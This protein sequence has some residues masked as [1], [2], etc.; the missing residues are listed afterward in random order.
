MTE[1][2]STAYTLA[3]LSEYIHTLD[4]LPID[5]SRNFADLRE[6]DA[7][8]SS[9]IQSITAKIYKLISMIED[10]TTTNAD[11]LWLLSDIAAEAQRLKVGGEDKIR[12]A[13]QGADNL[14]AHAGHLRALTEHIPGFDT[15][16]LDRKTT[17]PH[18]SDRAYMP[19][20]IM[21]TGRRRRGGLGSIMVATNPEPSPAK[22]KRVLKE[23]DVDVIGRSPKKSIHAESSARARNNGRKK[24]AYIHVTFHESDCL[25]MYRNERVPSPSESLVSVAAPLPHQITHST[26]SRISTNI[27]HRTGGASDGSASNK[28]RTGGTNTI[29]GTPLANEA[30]SA[31]HDAHAHIHTNGSSRRNGAPA[32][33]VFNRH[34]HLPPPASHP[35]LPTP[36]QNGNG[37]GGGGGGSHLG[38]GYDAHGISHAVVQDWNGIPRA[39]QLGGPGMPVRSASIH[40]TAASVNVINTANAHMDTDT[41]DADG[42]G[43]DRTYCF[44]DGISYGEMIACDDENCERE[45]VRYDL[46]VFFFLI[47]IRSMLC[48]STL[49]VLALHNL[50]K[51]SGIATRARTRKQ[52]R[53]LFGVGREEQ[54][55]TGQAEGVNQTVFHGRLVRTCN[56][57]MYQFLY[58][59]VDQHDHC[60]S[61]CVELVYF[62]GALNLECHQH[63]ANFVVFYHNTRMKSLVVLRCKTLTG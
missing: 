42:D 51:A 39:Q 57:T 27:N 49:V 31:S 37:V 38:N 50:H 32:S 56:K 17:Y 7:V 2:H 33:E 62:N 25:P 11:R 46:I 24:C 59:E 5:L 23:D 40:S 10:D 29:R 52:G 21:E 35:S 9:S 47:F 48:S 4:S 26:S 36:Y 14:K 34:H 54:V 43:D 41:G 3:L 6:L 22:R 44:C 13:C 30:Y 20:F 28:R 45:W 1:Y 12:V 8:L 53:G 60:K 19:T 58:L 15:S 55:E 63:P 16:A 61:V 18:V